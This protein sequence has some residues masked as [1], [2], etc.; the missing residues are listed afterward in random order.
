MARAGTQRRLVMAMLTIRNVEAGIK[1][2]LRLR[3]AR[4]RRSMEAELRHIL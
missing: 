3:A 4:N 2:R 1:E